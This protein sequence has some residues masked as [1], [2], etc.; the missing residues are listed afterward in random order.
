MK[1]RLELGVFDQR[2]LLLELLGG[3]CCVGHMEMT[4]DER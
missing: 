1:L 2:C 3:C 4:N